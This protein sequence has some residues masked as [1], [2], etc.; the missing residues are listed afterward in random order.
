[1]IRICEIDFPEDC[2]V[3][4]NDFYDYD[5]A[6][7]FN[8]SDSVKYLDEDLLQCSFPED[9]MIIDLGWYGDVT[10]NKG[11]FRINLIHHENWEIPLN[12]IHSKSPEEVKSLLTKILQY[13]SRIEIDTEI[14]NV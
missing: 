4:R 8:E 9:N 10:S 5:P 11:E 7:S 3:V 12:T 6:R 2:T 14:D 13:Y 1:M